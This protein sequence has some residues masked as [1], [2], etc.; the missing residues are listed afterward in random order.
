MSVTVKIPNDSHPWRCN[1]NGVEYVY[2]AGST[3]SVP[4]EV[5]QLIH[6][7]ET[8]APVPAPV[9]PPI[10]PELPA[11][12]ASDNGKLLGVSAGKWDKVSETKE[13]PAY[14]SSD[15]GKVLKVNSG[16]TG[17]E[18]GAASG[19][20]AFVINVS[21]DNSVYTMD[22]TAQEILSAFNAG[23][24]ILIKYPDE[25]FY[26]NSYSALLGIAGSASDGVVT[27]YSIK[28]LFQG[29][30]EEFQATENG[31]WYPQLSFA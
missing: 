28:T 5:A 8:S 26:K 13:L 30:V 12:S 19:G 6:E 24:Y 3:Q 23:S 18:W 7:I 14:T 25:E 10:A 11:V 22:K 15:N 17:V 4:E 9:D 1:I 2:A 21:V 20:G 16:G 31:D 29:N 27:G